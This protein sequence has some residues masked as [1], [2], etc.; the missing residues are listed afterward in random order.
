MK[1]IAGPK[2]TRQLPARAWLQTG[3]LAGLA[4]DFCV[5]YSAEDARREG[6]EVVV[7]EDACRSIDVDGSV[8]ATRKQFES[9]GIRCI[10]ASAF[11]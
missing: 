4:F 10:S 6:F 3:V 5:R 11:T 9:L 7:F 2:R 1:T 8:A